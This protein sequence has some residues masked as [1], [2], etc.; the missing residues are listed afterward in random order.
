MGFRGLGF[1]VSGSLVSRGG[2]LMRRVFFWWLTRVLQPKGGQHL[3][4][5]SS[6]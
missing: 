6:R 4:A 2:L 1:R 5:H 3:V